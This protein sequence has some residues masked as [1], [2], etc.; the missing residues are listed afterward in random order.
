MN[1]TKLINHFIQAA[2]AYVSDEDAIRELEDFIASQQSEPA[3]QRSTHHYVP[4]TV[5]GNCCSDIPQA[6]DAVGESTGLP[7]TDPHSY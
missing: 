6:A 4:P 3:Y 1:C 2:T 7:M 5:E